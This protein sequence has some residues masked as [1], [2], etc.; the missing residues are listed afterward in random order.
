[1]SA[2]AH[3]LIRPRVR[4]GNTLVLVTAILVLLVILATAFLVRAQSSRAQAG[5]Q[6]RAA[7]RIDRVEAIADA[8]V[9]DVADSLFVRPIDSSSFAAQVNAN[10]LAG[11]TGTAA[12]VARSDYPR[13]PANPLAIRY[14]VDY[15]D[16]LDNSTLGLLGSGD[17]YVDGYNYAPFGVSPWTNWP[18]WLGTTLWGEGNPVGSPG[19]GDT[20]WLRSTEPLRALTMVQGPLPTIAVPPAPPNAQTSPA[21]PGNNWGNLLLIGGVPVLSPEGLGFSHWS[22]LSW[23]PSAEN[24]FRV[25]YDISDIEAYTLAGFPGTPAG[26]QAL[27]VPY[28]QWLTNVPPREVELSGKDSRGYLVLDRTY[29]GTTVGGDWVDRRNQWFTNYRNV[30]VNNPMDALPNFL[31]LSAYGDPS[32][33]FKFEPAATVLAGA[34]TSRNLISRTFADAD[35]DGF[36]DSFWFVAPASSDRDTRQVVAVSITDNS[37]LLNVNIATRFNRTNTNGLTPSDLALVTL[38]ESFGQAAGTQGNDSANLDTLVG[39]L[40]SRENDPEYRASRK[41]PYTTPSAADLPYLVYPRTASGGAPSSGVDVGFEPFRWE[42]PR[43]TAAAPAATAADF[44]QPSFMQS[45][46]LMLSSATSGGAAVPVP[47]F[48][49][50]S[51]YGLGAAGGAGYGGWY[52]LTRPADRLTYF[53]AQANGGELVDPVTTAR[54]VTLSPFGMDDEIELRAAN[55]LNSAPTVSRLEAVLGN[56]GP[57]AIGG[58]GVIGQAHSSLVSNNA[59]RS[60]RS[61]EESVRFLEPNDPRS[62]DWR[63][64]WSWAGPNAGMAARSGAEL[65]LDNRRKLTTTSGARNEQLPPRLWTI[66]DPTAPN[67]LTRVKPAYIKMGVDFNNDGTPD[68]I[69]GDG[70][71][72]YFPPYDPRV[73]FYNTTPRG[74]ANGDGVITLVDAELARQEFLRR[75]RKIDLRRPTDIP[76]GTGAPA[77]GADIA[78]AER[79]FRVDVQRMMRRALID[80]DTRGSYFLGGRPA[81]MTAG[82]VNKALT[83]TK[84]MAAS[85]AANLG[86]YRDSERRLT[87]TLQLDGPLHPDDATALPSDAI[88]DPLYTNARFIGVEKQPF[89]QE[90]FIAYVYPK[91]RLTQAE[92]DAVT[93]PAGAPNADCPDAS[94]CQL[95]GDNYALP[96]CTANGAGEHFVAYDPAVP[97]T[98]PAV[99]FVAQ[100][101]NP[102]NEPVNLADFELRINPASGAPQRFFFGL[103]GPNGT[104]SGNTYGADV[105]LGPCTPEEPRTA[106]VFSVPGTFPNGDP[107][108]RDAWLDFL[109]IRAPIS[110]TNPA[111]DSKPGEFFEPDTVALFAPAWGGPGGAGNTQFHTNNKRGG[112]LLFDATR[113]SVPAVYAGLDVS[114]DMAR[115]QP[116]QSV[117][118]PP[119]ASFIELRRALYRQTGGT[120]SWTVVDRFDNELDTQDQNFKDSL[121]RLYTDEHLPP[122]KDIDCRQGK[123]AIGGIR[124][125]DNDYYTTWARGARQWLFDTQNGS[126]GA[127]PAGKGVITLDERTPRYGFSRLTGVERVKT[128]QTDVY[129]GSAQS[130]RKGVVFAETEYPDGQTSGQPW[131]VMEYRNIWGE[132]R[133]GKPTFFSTRIFEVP[134]GTDRKYPTLNDLGNPANAWRLPNATPSGGFQANYG[135]KGVTDAKFVDGTDPE[136]FIAPY[137]FFQKDRDFEQVAEILDV[138]LWGPLVEASAGGGAGRTY[139]TLPEILIQE[140]DTTNPLAFPKAPKAANLA[141]WNRL[142][143]D[144]ARYDVTPGPGGRPNLLSGVPVVPSPVG[145]I[146]PQQAGLVLLD[147]FTVDDR[148]AAPF[149]GDFSGTIDFPERAAAE[150]RRLR[151]A[152]GYQAK[153]TPGLINVNTAPIEVLRAMPQMTRLVYDN[154]KRLDGRTTVVDNTMQQATPQDFP[155]SPTT[156]FNSIGFDYGVPAP[157][158]RVAEAIDLWRTKGNINASHNGVVDPTLPSYFSRG[159][160]FPDANNNLEHAPGMRQERGFD[161]LGELALLTKGA[162]F[163]DPTNPQAADVAN[164][165]NQVAGWSVRYAGLDPF[166]TRYD[167]ATSGAAV[168]APISAGPTAAPGASPYRTDGIP[169]AGGAGTLQYH[170]LSGRTAIDPHKLVVATVDRDGSINGT[171]TAQLPA[172]FTDADRGLTLESRY[173]LTAGDAIEQNSLLKGISNLVTTRSDVFTVHMRVR[174]I[175]RNPIT[176]RWDATDPEFMLDE[177]RY[178]MGV[179][180]S[181]VDRP[182]EKPRVMY[183]TKVPN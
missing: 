100:I 149:D 151:L 54:L 70:Q 139:A 10:V 97:A 52:L 64:R 95:G 170:S 119:P 145:F 174:T 160:D 89:L 66:I 146:S 75:N 138:P 152:Q 48:D 38:R 130:Q 2:I 60:S 122:M 124:I 125:R 84:L 166:R 88:A 109:D 18:D 171:P 90:V 25:C 12:N 158:V 132:A 101:A 106:I 56:A 41:N 21:A 115:W 136:N 163:V 91:T 123:L 167:D 47:M 77:N 37:A 39:F 51:D 172:G 62:M 15:F 72:D 102:Y 99:V 126:T 6:Q 162:N 28:E 30:I 81:D 103:P 173:D 165:W 134:G 153:L 141:Y 168:L 49:P 157:R 111:N 142:Q 107:F 46:G 78:L 108:P 68:D 69:D 93:G 71:P 40:N 120:P 4:R 92:L 169:K 31:Q 32:D 13:L 53:K 128:T 86:T 110:E 24:G 73:V 3:T 112:T 180:R 61:R 135:E 57:V 179:D 98:W 5:A 35:G 67:D 55:G 59:L 7:G 177:S 85:Y 83:A 183:F 29:N 161:S 50:T 121:L 118:G 133:R 65:L 154:D 137:R 11:I 116:Q 150:N 76:T 63:A 17:G 20:R 178:V 34:P 44:T 143:L 45:M 58:T 147:A 1:M 164:S 127:F 156:Q 87:S 80:E 19:F 79:E 16:Q 159:L 114:G 94:G 23:L 117:G 105:E 96:P 9:Q 22:H 33:E 14:G 82:D 74:D 43:T 182:G 113:T 131:M 175:K 129:V 144:P 36:T 42:G 140:P 104:R 8:I 176:G 155:Q 26:E 148:G 27:G 181:N